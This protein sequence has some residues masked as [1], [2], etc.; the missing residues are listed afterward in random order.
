MSPIKVQLTRDVQQFC[1]FL[2]EHVGAS[3]AVVHGDVL[4]RDEG[5]DI[6]GSGAGVLT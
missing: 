3:D 4:D 5:A 6:H 1:Q 2:S